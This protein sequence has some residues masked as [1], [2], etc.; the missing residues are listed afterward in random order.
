MRKQV[1][2]EFETSE[3]MATIM[4]TQMDGHKGGLVGIRLSQLLGPSVI[5][6]VNASNAGN[7]ASVTE[8]ANTLFSKL[9]PEEFERLRKDLLHGAT[10]KINGEVH[11]FDET[12]LKNYF[13]GHF[14][15]LLKLVAFALKVNFQSFL[16]DLG[17]SDESVKAMGAL[18]SKMSGSK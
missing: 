18:A 10:L 14:G 4:V 9:S 5:A 8:A 3:G 17:V 15:S 13:A 16:K 2:A 1:E 12:I 7:T 6:L 11:D